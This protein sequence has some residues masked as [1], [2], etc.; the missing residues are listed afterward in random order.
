MRKMIWLLLLSLLLASC[1]LPAR[2]PV[3]EEATPSPVSSATSIPE[4]ATP[5]P[6]L[7]PPTISPPSLT[8][9][10]QLPVESILILEPGPGSRLT[11]PIHVRGMADSTFEQHL[12]VNV[13]SVDG[14]GLAFT[15]VLIQSEMG[16][17]GPF[18]ID[19]P[20]DVSG[21]VAAFIQVYASS[22]RD[23]GITHLSAV[24]VH[25]V[26][27]GADDIHP[28]IPDAERINIFK[29]T[30]TEKIG[31]GVAHVEGFALAS[32]EQTLVVD[33]IDETGQVVGSQAVI[34]TAPDMGVP[35]PFSADVPYTV[36]AS[37]PGRIVVRDPSVA[38]EGDVHVASVEVMLNP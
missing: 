34:V 2:T 25:L 9:T 33:V 27:S 8:S 20:V 16:T 26:E 28:V 11:S 19:I 24:G 3:P 38:F 17:R 29:P 5:T 1:N 30:V 31:G 37:G 6:T 21:E 7:I 4:E 36:T 12:V 10:P 15:P 13:V 35:G 32:F 18:E 22:P 23:G 14:T